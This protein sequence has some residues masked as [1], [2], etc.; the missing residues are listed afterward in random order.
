MYVSSVCDFT[1]YRCIHEEP[2]S[3][4]KLNKP[5]NGRQFSNALYQG[6]GALLY[7]DFVD[8]SI[9]SCCGDEE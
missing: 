5:V 2:E 7:F 4:G 1:V 6:S 9:H 3:E 8:A